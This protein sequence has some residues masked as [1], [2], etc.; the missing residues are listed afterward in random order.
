M[1]KDNRILGKFTL[2]GVPPAPRGVPQIEVIFDVDANG[3]LQ[4]SAKDLG[5]GQ[6]QSIRIESASGL[7]KE[8]IAR[9][10][11][12]ATEMSEEDKRRRAM[13]DQRNFADHILYTTEKM[14]EA[15]G[16]KIG[17]AQREAIATAMKHL[18]EVRETSE[19]ETIRRAIE[20]LSDATR[21][22]SAIAYPE[23]I[24]RPAQAQPAPAPAPA[25]RQAPPTPTTEREP[26]V[27][28]EFKVK[29]E[30]EQ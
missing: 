23:G 22:L 5:S 15:H 3:I 4:V 18:R 16:A 8:E 7:T 30:K 28:A 25:P 14:V 1:S 12:E 2:A 27:D 29:D 10:Q 6:E 13:A 17:E 9:M 11:K 26:V 19:M 21:P 20:A 24:G